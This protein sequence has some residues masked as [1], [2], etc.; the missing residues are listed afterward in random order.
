MQGLSQVTSPAVRTARKRAALQQVSGA[1]ACVRISCASA[2]VTRLR[3]EAYEVRKVGLG[4]GSGAEL[5]WREGRVGG[6]AEP[7][8]GASLALCP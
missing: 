5:H 4:V 8:Q 1:A 3:K 6:S 2:R 7:C